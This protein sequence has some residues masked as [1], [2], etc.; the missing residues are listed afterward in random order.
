MLFQSNESKIYGLTIFLSI[1]VFQLLY[2]NLQWYYIRRKEYFYYSLYLFFALIYAIEEFERFLPVKVFT[3][4]D[5]DFHAHVEHG[6]PLFCFFFY[7]R[8]ARFFVDLPTT[9]PKLNGQV[10]WLEYVI[11]GYSIFEITTRYAGLDAQIGTYIFYG[12]T[13]FLFVAVFRIV[14]FFLRKSN[15]LTSFMIFG[16]SVNVLGSVTTALMLALQLHG[17]VLPFDPFLPLLIAVIIEQIAFTT[18]LAYKSRLDSIDKLKVQSELIR[19]LEENEA[20]HQKMYETR[21]K[22]ARDLHDNIGSTLG[23]I[24]YFS[25]MARMKGNADPSVMLEKIEE[26]SRESI[27]NMN[28]I[29]WA[30]QPK[31]ENME[32]LLIRMQNFAA[33]QASAKQV[34]L[35]F[36]MDDSVKYIQLNMEAYKNLFLVFKE[37]VYNVMKYAESDTVEV[38]ISVN[39]GNLQL[40]VKDNGKGFDVQTFSS[41]NGNGLRNMKDRAKEIGAELNIVSEIGKGTIVTLSLQIGEVEQ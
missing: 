29:V 9:R 32:A 30:I 25:E 14:F 27:D 37:A 4:F 7:Y 26:A 8:F 11:L 21:S 38:S 34:V 16:A 20:L 2:I 36:R 40:Q 41:Y 13:I 31:N 24:S 18:G 3:N 23:S 6:L 5:P 33:D 15:A 17:K 10:K 35:D 22:I 39:T 1:G 19:K 28:D 12:I